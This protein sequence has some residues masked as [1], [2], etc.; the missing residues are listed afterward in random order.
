MNQIEQTPP[1][2]LRL[3]RLR[4]ALELASAELEE[5]VLETHVS[6]TWAIAV[7]SA[8]QDI[9]RARA[10]VLSSL[11]ALAAEPNAVVK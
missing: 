8:Q 2:Q 9:N 6:D 7:L 3:L 1:E 5:A 11:Q 10:V 4:G